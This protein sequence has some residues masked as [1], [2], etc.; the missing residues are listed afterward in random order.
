MPDRFGSGPLD[1]WR[2]VE[3]RRRTINVAA[4]NEEPWF[5]PNSNPNSD[6][7]SVRSAVS[8]YTKVETGLGI[9]PDHAMLATWVRYPTRM[10]PKAEPGTFTNL[11][12][13]Y[14]QRN[15]KR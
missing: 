7:G 2:R 4:K 9:H 14:I 6:I 3:R 13:Q 1:S 15:E 10:L 12:Y 11:V 8:H 5:D